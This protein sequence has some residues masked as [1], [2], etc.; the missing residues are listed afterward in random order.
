MLSLSYEQQQVFC[1]F[2]ELA[3][4]HGSV[5]K[6]VEETNVNTKHGLAAGQK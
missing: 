6:P 3:K 1:Y 4:S 5:E 2:G